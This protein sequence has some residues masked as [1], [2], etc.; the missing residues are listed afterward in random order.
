MICPSGQAVEVA[1][2]DGFVGNVVMKLVEGLGAGAG[3]AG[4]EPEA[5]RQGAGSI[6]DKID[7]M[8]YVYEV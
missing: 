2:C 8:R 3:G 6:A 5:P 1:V 7:L 4:F